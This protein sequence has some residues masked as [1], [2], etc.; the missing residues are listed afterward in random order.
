MGP[1]K[2]A[3]SSQKKLSIAHSIGPVQTEELLEMEKHKRKAG[4]ENLSGVYTEPQNG[5]SR[6]FR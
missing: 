2:E 1:S 3:C 4:K 6:Q 5:L